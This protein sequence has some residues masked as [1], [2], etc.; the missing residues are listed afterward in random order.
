MPARQ[1]ES[2]PRVQLLAGFALLAVLATTEA[3][4]P[5]CSAGAGEAVEL[6]AGVEEMARVDTRRDG[7]LAVS[8]GPPAPLKP[9]PWQ[10][11]APCEPGETPIHTACYVETVMKP[12]CPPRFYEY[13]LKCFVAVVKAKGT[14]TSIEE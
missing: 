13:N 1:S 9:A 12:P 14:D 10:Q 8:A 3:A 7:G 4:A 6:D 11:R 2:F 5:G